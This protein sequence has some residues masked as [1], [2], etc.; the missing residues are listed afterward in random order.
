L[1]VIDQLLL[2]VIWLRCYPIQEVLG[3]AQFQK[4]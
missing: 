1:T 4:V 3:F 2:T